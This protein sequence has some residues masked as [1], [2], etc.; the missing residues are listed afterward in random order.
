MIQKPIDGI[1]PCPVC[2]KRPKISIRHYSDYSVVIFRC[3]PLFRK[4]H[5]EA[6]YYDI[7]E[8]WAFVKAMSYWNRRG[9]DG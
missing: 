4:T 5:F 7:S 1:I 2:G 6:G 3:K 9:N 8:R